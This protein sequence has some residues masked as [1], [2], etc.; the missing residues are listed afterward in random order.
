MEVMKRHKQIDEPSKKKVKLEREEDFR[1][2]PRSTVRK[3][4]PEG[5]LRNRLQP[6]ARTSQPVDD[7]R[8]RLQSPARTS[9]PADDLSHYR[10]PAAKNFYS[11]VAPFIDV[12]ANYRNSITCTINASDITTSTKRKV[13][14][15]FQPSNNGYTASNLQLFN[16][17][18]DF[19][20][21]L[22]H[23]DVDYRSVPNCGTVLARGNECVTSET[24]Q[25]K[26]NYISIAINTILAKFG[27]L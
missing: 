1:C 21:I 11:A 5:D 13:E 4:Q 18:A 9:Q 10:P 23:G 12:A 8:N 2:H 25:A 7:L 17:Q 22:S 16:K 3:F 27:S 15:H 19:V 24:K 6:P 20:N 14:T 26:G